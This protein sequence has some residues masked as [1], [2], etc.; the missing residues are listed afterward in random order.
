[1]KK[2]NPFFLL[3]AVI[4]TISFLGIGIFIAMESFIGVIAS[5]LLLVFIMGLGFSKKKKIN[6]KETV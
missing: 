6:A 3:L 1:L 2:V 5:I 4:A